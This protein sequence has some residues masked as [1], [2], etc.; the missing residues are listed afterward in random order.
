MNI[1]KATEYQLKEALETA[2]KLNHI[3]LTMALEATLNI[4]TARIQQGDD[5]VSMELS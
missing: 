2:Q 3:E 5:K 4:L 1:Y